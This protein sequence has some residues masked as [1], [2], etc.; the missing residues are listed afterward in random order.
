[1]GSFAI[2]AWAASATDMF[3]QYAPFSWVAAGF[4]GLF[5]TALIYAISALA[6]GRIVKSRYNQLLFSKSGFVDPMSKTFESKRIFLS[7]F[8][9]PS[10][11]HIEGKVFIGCDIVG[12]ANII[13][14]NN[15]QLADPH[16]PICDAVLVRP[17]R[18]ILNGIIIDSCTFRHCSFKR[19]TIV[20]P[21]NAF[22]QFEHLDWLNWLNLA[23]PQTPN[24][25]EAG[26]SSSNVEIESQPQLSIGEEKQQ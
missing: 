18:N 13:L 7:E 1:M 19:V 8:C 22:H 24:E 9:L 21:A 20:V 12:P 10:E 15:N 6:Y 26:Q 25:A 2:P 23:D 11:Q 14:R 3:A 17:D 4:C 5:L 16:L